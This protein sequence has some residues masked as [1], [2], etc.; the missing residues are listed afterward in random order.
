MANYVIY[1]CGQ[2]ENYRCTVRDYSPI[3]GKLDPSVFICP[4]RHPFVK[5]QVSEKKV[6]PKLPAEGSAEYRAAV[7]DEFHPPDTDDEVPEW[8]PCMKC[9]K[10]HGPPRD[11]GCG[12]K[13]E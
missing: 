9:G 2:C 11:A 7:G 8:E 12:G 1:Q 6:E 5:F 13:P 4:L 10:C 3:A